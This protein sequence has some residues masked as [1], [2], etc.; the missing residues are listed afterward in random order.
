M[1]IAVEVSRLWVDQSIVSSLPHES[2]GIAD[3]DIIRVR[4]YTR[5]EKSVR[6][7]I[8]NAVELRDRAI[9]VEADIMDVKVSLSCDEQLAMLQFVGFYH[10]PDLGSSFKTLQKW[11]PAAYVGLAGTFTSLDLSLMSLFDSSFATSHFVSP[12]IE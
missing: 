9:K 10:A 8:K 4:A 5:E 1:H 6:A 7:A 3:S 2:A 11:S 12:G